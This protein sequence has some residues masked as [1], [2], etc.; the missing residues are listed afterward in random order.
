MESLLETSGFELAPVAGAH[1][2]C[3][4][5]GTYSILQRDL[6]QRL[7]ADKLAALQAGDPELVVTANIG[8]LLH[9]QSASDRPVL[10]WLELL[11]DVQTRSAESED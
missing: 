5:A 10:H 4:S 8:C 1:L 7:L 9:L 3:G 6:S 11:D 2:C